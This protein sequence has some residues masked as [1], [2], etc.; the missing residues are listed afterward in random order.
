MT[1][2]SDPN[3]TSTNQVFDT[4]QMKSDPPS[5]VIRQ[6]ATCQRLG[7]SAM[8]LGA[9]TNIR[10]GKSR[11]IVHTSQT[12]VTRDM[13]GMYCFIPILGKKNL[14]FIFFSVDR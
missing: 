14:T 13:L 4:R 11:Q 2:T 5:N 7:A 12:S 3:I 1:C 6:M 10:Y 8:P 9:C